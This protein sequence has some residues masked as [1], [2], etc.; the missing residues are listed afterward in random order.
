M[1]GGCWIQDG[2]EWWLTGTERT[3]HDYYLNNVLIHEIGHINDQRNT[4]FAGHERN[5]D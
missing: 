2:S 1:F 3:I 5:A 4:R